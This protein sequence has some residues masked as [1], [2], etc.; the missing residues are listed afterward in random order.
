MTGWPELDRLLEVDPADGGCDH[1]REVLHVYAELVAEGRDPSA[2]Y[3][4]VAA[5]LRACPPCAEDL[6]GLLA[7]IAPVSS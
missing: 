7:L 2:A 3:P 1:A 6:M 5:H 4:A